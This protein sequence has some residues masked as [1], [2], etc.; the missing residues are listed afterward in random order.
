MSTLTRHLNPIRNMF[1][2]DNQDYDPFKDFFNNF[3]KALSDDHRLTDIKDNGD[4]YTVSIELPGYK[5]G[6]VKAEV[7][8][9]V[10]TVTAEKDGKTSYQNSF[11]I[12]NDV[13]TKSITANLEYGILTLTLPKKEVSKPRKIKVQ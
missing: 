2:L 3:S 4:V 11:S 12:K 9:G 6:D 10:L 8:D 1:L 13:D 5:K 7:N